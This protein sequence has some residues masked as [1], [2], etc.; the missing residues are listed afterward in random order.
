M[1][2]HASECA[3]CPE[4]NQKRRGSKSHFDSEMRAGGG[5]VLRKSRSFQGARRLSLSLG[6]ILNREGRELLIQ[7][8]QFP[9]Q[10]REKG[11]K[12]D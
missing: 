7:L 10:G 11:D 1:R 12:K 8:L 4:D 6:G 2:I 5:E 3:D 9:D